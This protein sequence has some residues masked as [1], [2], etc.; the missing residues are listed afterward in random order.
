M[1]PDG[2]APTWAFRAKPGAG[3]VLRSSVSPG[4][5]SRENGCQIGSEARATPLAVYL[6]W[7]GDAVEGRCQARVT[8]DSGP[9]SVPEWCSTWNLLRSRRGS[10]SNFVGLLEA[11]PSFDDLGVASRRFERRLPSPLE[12]D[13]RESRGCPGAFRV[14]PPTWPH[15]PPSLSIPLN[16]SIVGAVAEG[17]D[18][19][20]ESSSSSLPALIEWRGV[21]GPQGPKPDRP[22]A[23]QPRNGDGAVA[24]K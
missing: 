21:S 15:R 22:E 3:E 12:D 11:L 4:T 23:S 17:R 7:S 9:P 16:E 24:Q 5:S 2:S 20:A 8:N 19:R 1:T 14:A 6:G 13:R 10:R 18:D